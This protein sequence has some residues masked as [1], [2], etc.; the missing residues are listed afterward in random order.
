MLQLFGVSEH[1][2]RTANSGHYTATVRNSRDGK[3]YRYNDS[4]VGS[5]TGDAAISGGAYLL[6][7]KRITGSLKWAGMEKLMNPQP[8]VISLAKSNGNHSKDGPNSPT[9]PRNKKTDEDG[10]TQVKSKKK[11]K[12]RGSQSFSIKFPHR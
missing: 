7:Y 11:K 8:N 12:T 5:T 2:G 10:F 4:H 6:F 1:S 9:D 3:W